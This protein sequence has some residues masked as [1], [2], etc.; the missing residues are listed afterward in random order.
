M[1]KHGG[2]P[3][4]AEPKTPDFSV[5]S[6]FLVGTGPLHDLRG[7]AGGISHGSEIDARKSD[8]AVPRGQEC[9]GDD[10]VLPERIWSYRSMRLM[11]PDKRIGHAELELAP[12]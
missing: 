2:N 5:F 12:G 6:E 9:C 4:A 11:M 1:F 10:R 7:P 3:M 8:N